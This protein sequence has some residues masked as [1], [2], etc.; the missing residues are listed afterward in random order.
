[1]SAKGGGVQRLGSGQAERG[2]LSGCRLAFLEVAAITTAQVHG[3]CYHP[4]AF[5]GYPHWAIKAGSLLVY[6]DVFLFIT[7][8]GEG[9]IPRAREEVKE[10]KECNEGAEEEGQ[11]AAGSK[12]MRPRRAHCSDNEPWKVGCRRRYG[13]LLAFRLCSNVDGAQLREASRELGLQR[14]RSGLVFVD[15]LCANAYAAVGEAGAFASEGKCQEKRSEAMRWKNFAT[16]NAALN[17]RLPTRGGGGMDEDASGGR[18]RERGDGGLTTDVFRTAQGTRT[19][20]HGQ[21]GYVVTFTLCIHICTPLCRTAATYC[22][23]VH[24]LC[25]PLGFTCDIC[26]MRLDCPPRCRM[27]CYQATS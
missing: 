9:L 4:I 6:S 25:R 19:D 14:R 18:E 10:R 16:Y 2:S 1:M 13:S 15:R 12:E 26:R 24:V 11:A 17:A 8:L 7:G 27:V 3:W 21:G 23:A 20:T 5:L 22:H